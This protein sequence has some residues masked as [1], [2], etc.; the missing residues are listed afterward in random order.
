VDLQNYTMYVRRRANVH[1]MFLVGK[2]ARKIPLGRPGYR[3]NYSGSGQR[4]VGAP[5]VNM[6]TNLRVP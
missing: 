5:L 1:T 2:P 3:L 6:V 4:H